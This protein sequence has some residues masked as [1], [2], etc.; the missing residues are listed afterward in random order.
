ML[1]REYEDVKV[2]VMY[3]SS[4]E[5]AQSDFIEDT[6]NQ[7][8]TILTPKS[9]RIMDRT[10]H[11]KNMMNLPKC[12]QTLRKTLEILLLQTRKVNSKEPSNFLNQISSI[13]LILNKIKE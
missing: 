4:L 7:R 13:N 12:L 1:H 6:V 8:V 2:D 3:L 5:Y 10:I 11:P 9:M